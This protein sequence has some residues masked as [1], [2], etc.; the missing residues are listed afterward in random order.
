MF[1]H[2]HTKADNV[3]PDAKN[4]AKPTND[5]VPDVKPIA[6]LLGKSITKCIGQTE[7]KD[8]ETKPEYQYPTPYAAPV[9]FLFGSC[10]E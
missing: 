2:A 1:L 10:Y 9:R 3:T 8:E 4:D 5:A 6:P 7:H